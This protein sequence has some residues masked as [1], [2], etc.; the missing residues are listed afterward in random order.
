M[1]AGGAAG[2]AAAPRYVVVTVGTLGDIHPFVRLAQAL[3]AHGR[4]VTFLTNPFHLDLLRATGLPV[5]GFGSAD[6]Y[7]RVVRDPDVWHPRRGFAA[8]MSRYQEQLLQYVAA[9]RPLAQGGPPVV[10]AHPLAVPGAAAARELGLVSR[11]VSVHLAPSS[12]RTCHDPLRIGPF[13]MPR[14][15]PM[16]WRRAYW[17]FVERGWIDPVALRQ[18]ND[19]RSLLDLPPLH[20]SFLTQIEQAPDLTVTL[21]PEWFGP[22]MP[23]WPRPRI[24]GDFQ[25]FDAQPANAFSTELADFL[26]RGTPPLVFTPGTGNLHASRFFACALGAAARLGERAILLTRER[27]QLPA[28]LPDTALWQAYVPLAGLLPRARGLIHHGG[29]GTTAEALRAGTPQVVTPFAWDQFDNGARV[30]SLGVG[31]VL[32]AARLSVRRLT[33][34]IGSTLGAESTGERC[35]QVAQRF[36]QRQDPARLCGQIEDALLSAASTD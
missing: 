32:P 1:S 4:E 19:A 35:R 6:D 25:L 10:V 23:D 13:T 17:R 3:R 26:A 11:I 27:G 20:A 24:A 16:R 36:A 33:A 2:A 14:W 18:I 21:F 7:L 5:A 22:A 34:A 29:V 9:M 30:A 15:V 12:L 8:L 28:E 31:A